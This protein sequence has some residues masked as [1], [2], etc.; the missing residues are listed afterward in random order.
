MVYVCDISTGQKLYLTFQ[1][2]QTTVISILSAPGQQQQ[3]SQSFRTGAWTEP[4]QVLRSPQGIFITLQTAQGPRVI[5][6]Q[7]QTLQAASSLPPLQQA[8][9]IQLTEAATMPGLSEIPPLEP[10]PPM[11]P[12]PAMPPLQMG[13][14]SLKPMEMRMGNMEMRMGQPL[15][16]AAQTG[17]RRNFCSQC[18]APVQPSDRFCSSCGHQFDP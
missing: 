12:L 4:P 10:L 13:N 1:G 17:P 14:M 2:E 8:E 18:G 7:G 16:P 9:Q 15:T 11:T 5:Q 3:S 6:V